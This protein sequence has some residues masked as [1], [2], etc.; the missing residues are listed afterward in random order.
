MLQDKE[1]GNVV[2][3][4]LVKFISTNEFLAVSH[5]MADVLGIV[6]RVSMVFQRKDL[7]FSVLNEV[8]DPACSAILGMKLF[9]GPRLE[10]FLAQ[11]PSSADDSGEFIFCNAMRYSSSQSS[12][13]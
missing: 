6:C 8:L 7:T 2:A 1:D 3:G 5:L 10:S 12:H 13:F 4:D 9:P 11:V